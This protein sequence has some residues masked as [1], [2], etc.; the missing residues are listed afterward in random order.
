[1]QVTHAHAALTTSDAVDESLT[2][3]VARS[4]LEAALAE[5]ESSTLWFEVGDDEDSR[6]IE[7]DLSTADMEELLR[8]SGN[9][10][11]ALSL[12]GN[13]IAG[14]FD[15]P[16]VEAHGLKGA[17]AIVV[18]SAAL[19]APAGQ[20]AVTQSVG[21][22]ATTQGVGVA[23]TTQGVGVAATTQG[24]GVAATTNVSHAAATAQV[25]S[26]Q[27]KL[28]RSSAAFKLQN[29]KVLRGGLFR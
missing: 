12:D 11:V 4:V 10:D 9:E 17:I 14:L 25:A 26:A 20:A 1:M 27:A 29:L 16:E 6:R 22:A 28:A 2:T 7:V 24:V 23:A 5:G 8:M 19:L 15:D 18:T 3:I 21:A 13:E